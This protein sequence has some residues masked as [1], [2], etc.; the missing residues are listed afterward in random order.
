[1]ATENTDELQDLKVVLMRTAIETR[2]TV[3]DVLGELTI[4]C[5]LSDTDHPMHVSGIEFRKK[6]DDGMLSHE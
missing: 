3:A 1:M 4:E 2:R 6:I 5:L